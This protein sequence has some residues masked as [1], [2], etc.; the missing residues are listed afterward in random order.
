M[1]LE[2]AKTFN[3]LNQ[4]TVIHRLDPRSKGFMVLVFAVLAILAK[5]LA[6]IGTLALIALPILIL[7]HMIPQFL[8]GLAG[9]S[10]VD[11]RRGAPI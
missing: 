10:F 2:F 1:S 8:K 9:L 4:D 3:F 7:S 11:H 5:D 6:S